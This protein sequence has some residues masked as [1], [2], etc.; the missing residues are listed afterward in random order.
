MSLG[1]PQKKCDLVMKGGVTS[2]VVYPRAITE[3]S[4]EYHMLEPVEN[5][6]LS[7][8]STNCQSG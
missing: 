6:M 8:K 2:G 4:R 7:T 3:L 1:R 5:S